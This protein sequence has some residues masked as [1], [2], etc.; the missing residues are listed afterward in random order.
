MRGANFD[1]RHI[2]NYIFIF[3]A[4]RGAEN[5]FKFIFIG[6][7][8]IHHFIIPSPE[9][10]PICCACSFGE[11]LVKAFCVSQNIPISVSYCS[12]TSASNNSSFALKITV[13]APVVTS[14]FLRFCAVMPIE[15]LFRKIQLCSR[16]NI[17]K[18]IIFVS[19]HFQS[20]AR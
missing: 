6:I 9:S 7:A 13:N 4:V 17:I 8:I 19:I 12:P 15:S 20:S 1:F 14:A 5:K 3:C 11:S 18:R 2:V 10:S 16:Q